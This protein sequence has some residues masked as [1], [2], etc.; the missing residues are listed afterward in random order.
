MSILVNKPLFKY[1]R[2]FVNEIQDIQEL[3]CVILFG[4]QAREDYTPDSDLD[5]LIIGYFQKKFINRGV[6]IQDKYEG[7]PQLDVFFYTPKEFHKM[8]F[9]VIDSILD[10]IDHGICLMGHTFFNKYKNLLKELKERRLK[11]GSSGWQLPEF[12]AFK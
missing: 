1:L 3:Q 12:I 4:S 9:E 7:E 8:F 2:V 6:K 11:R 5:L 10:S